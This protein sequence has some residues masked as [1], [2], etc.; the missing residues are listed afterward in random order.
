[1]AQLIIQTTAAR[2][3]LADATYEL[4]SVDDTS[5]FKITDVIDDS[6]AN[7]ILATYPEFSLHPDAVPNE[8]V[9]QTPLARSKRKGI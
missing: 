5:G 8:D 6:V 1:M 4:T 7:D 3:Q 9:V 2:V